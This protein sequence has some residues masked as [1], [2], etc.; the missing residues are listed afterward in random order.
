[1]KIG[2]IG[3]HGHHYLTEILSD[4]GHDA[5]WAGDGHDDD[6]ARTKCDRLGITAWYDDARSMLETF[7][8]DVVNVGAVYGYNGD[9]I[10][11]VLGRGIPVVSDKPVAATEAQLD[12]LRRLATGDARLITEFPFRS[13]PPFRA[14]HDAVR[15]GRIGEPVLATAQKSYRFNARPAWFGDRAAYGGT[16]LWVASHAIDAIEYVTGLRFVRVIGRGGNIA[17]GEYAEME[18]HCVLIGE[19]ERGA[20]AVVHADYLRPSGAETHGDDRL[21]LAGSTGVLEI[22]DGVCSLIDGTGS[23]ELQPAATPVP[24][25]RALLAAALGHDS[26][27]YGTERS[28][29]TAAL[30]L[31]CRRAADDETWVTV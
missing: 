15:A 30:L 11:E 22:R 9:A 7:R 3:G 19:L 14:A 2:F 23:A 31:A 20:S 26:A 13:R 6:A 5:A 25:G 21:R 27:L 16:M 4:D 8:P 10:A 17:K 29:R 1:M 24:A 28:L 18:D 12:R